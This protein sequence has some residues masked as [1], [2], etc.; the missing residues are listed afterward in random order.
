M[1]AL[2]DL[3]TNLIMNIYI[4]WLWLKIPTTNN[5]KNNRLPS[6]VQ[7]LIVKRMFLKPIW[8]SFISLVNKLTTKIHITWLMLSVIHKMKFTMRIKTFAYTFYCIKDRSLKKK[9]RSL[10]ITNPN[11][12]FNSETF[13]MTKRKCNTLVQFCLQFKALWLRTFHVSTFLL[14]TEMENHCFA[15]F[16][17]F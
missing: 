4:W 16:I 11:K 5:L 3:Q 17:L 9:K 2:T 8:N 1:D 6:R 12:I 13:T 14:Q 15:H 10:S 7:V